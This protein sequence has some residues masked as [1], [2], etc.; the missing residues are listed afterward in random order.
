MIDINSL[1]FKE[2]LYN[3][4]CSS[5]NCFEVLTLYIL[6]RVELCQSSS[7]D[8]L[9][10]WQLMIESPEKWTEMWHKLKREPR[11]SL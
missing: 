1:L 7:G 11:D 3:E 10:H 9:R 2:V 5:I 8:A 4:K 6:G